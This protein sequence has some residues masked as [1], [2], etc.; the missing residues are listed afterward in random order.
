MAT[1]RARWKRTHCCGELR[2][3]HIGQDV[4]LN[5]WVH[6][7]RDHGGVI[8]LDL[9]D[10]SGLVQVVF[11]PREDQEAHDIASSTRSEFVLS[12]P[13][14]VTRRPEGTENPDLATGEIE[15]RATGIEILGEAKTPP[16]GIAETVE[17]D[18]NI[19]LR[20]RYLDLRSQRMQDNM[21]GRHEAIAAT[22]EYLHAQGFWDVQ[23]PLLIKSTPE[24][25]RDFLVPSRMNPGRFYALPQS[26]QLFK[27]LLMVAGVERYYQ[28]A[29]C[30]RDEDLRADRQFEFAQ[31][32]IEMAFVEQDDV[33]EVVEG[34]LAAVVE[35]VR[36]VEV[37]LPFPRLTHAEAMARY[38]SE[39]PD[40][41]FG[42]ELVD[43]TDL[44]RDVEFKVF[45][46][47]VADGG[48]VK[49]IK[50]EG[51]GLSRSQIDGPLL[52]RVKELGAKGL[53]WFQMKSEGLDS[54]IARFFKPEELEAIARAFEAQPGDV[55]LLVADAP[56]V[57]AQALGGLRLHLGRQLSLIPE[58]EFRFVWV[59]DFPLF[60]LDAE[61]NVVPSHH[62]FTMP[63]PD[64]LGKLETDPLA[65]RAW[66]YDV[67]LNGVELGGGS[68][69]IHKRDIQERV[70]PAIGLSQEEAREK[71]GFLLD[72]FEYGTPPHGGIALGMD[73][74]VMILQ[75]ETSIREVIAFPKSQSGMDL[76][77]GAPVPVDSRVL[78]ELH[79]KTDLPVYEK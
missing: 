18:E 63:H 23:T 75:G 62:P 24:G 68:I 59:T 10:R 72:A 45:S 53:A 66:A 52:E 15:V 76:M 50:V 31:I 74:L 77:T 48:Q 30:L 9:R 71:F 35:T 3:D 78:K 67:V 27:Q 2:P 49:G 22:R 5:G 46:A 16:F 43:V 60:E 25:A 26:P 8:F 21:R 28:I 79:I 13:G 70:F 40:L 6:R 7:W 56:D 54:S 42:M 20:Y 73:R 39:K 33:F 61:G 29:I 41:R 58:G 65:C 55:L 17:A 64:D 11:D 36:G 57:V 14:Q 47:T 1:E 12:V 51:G 32:D 38:G 19:R 34:M 4:V 37:S 44:V 69:R